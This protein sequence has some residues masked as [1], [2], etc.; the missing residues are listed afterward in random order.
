MNYH[1]FPGPQAYR[2]P[3][4]KVV[5]LSLCDCLMQTNLHQTSISQWQELPD[6][7]SYDIPEDE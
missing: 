2:A 6:D 1:N 3:F 4:C 7:D 5:E